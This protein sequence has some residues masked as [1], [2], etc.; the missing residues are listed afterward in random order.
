MRGCFSSFVLVLGSIGILATCAPQAFAIPAVSI[1]TNSTGGTFD[2]NNSGNWS[3]DFPPARTDTVSIIDSPASSQL[4]TNMGGSSAI[5]ATNTINLLVVSNSSESVTV[6]QAPGV[7]MVMSNGFQ[8]GQNATLVIVTNANLGSNSNVNFNLDAG[9]QGTLVLSNASA[10][11]GLSTFVNSGQVGINN[12]GTI[13]LSPN[14][15]QLVSINYGQT[16]LFTNN[17]IGTIVMKGTGTGAF[18]GNF[19]SNNERVL[20]N[21]SIFVQAGTL[22]VDS[23]NAFSGGGFQNGATGYIQINTNAAFELRRTT[24]AWTAG[25]AVTNLGTIFMNG[26]AMLAFDTDQNGNLLTNA[27]GQVTTTTNTTRVFENA[28][29]IKGNGTILATLSNLS[30]GTLAPGL[31]FQ[32]LNVGGSVTLGSNST[33]SVELGLL[34]GQEGLLDVGSNLTLNANSILS[35]SGGAVGNVYTVAVASAVSGTFG[36]VTPDYTVTYGSTDIAV[37]FVP[38]P[39]TIMLVVVGLGGIVA[40]RGRRRC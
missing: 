28:G 32:A 17:A 40:F 6:Q 26:G 9:G 19:S 36:S 31:G 11:A 37:Q 1:W 39:S 30:G 7:Y 22:R 4:I 2:W 24:N 34:A 14:G 38:E 21:G 25:T 12:S 3:G 8:L 18:I 33:F 20:N 15:N 35:L 13:P 23:R 5:G 27:L 29:I 16:G 10:T